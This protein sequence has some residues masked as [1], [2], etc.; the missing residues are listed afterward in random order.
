MMLAFLSL[1]L[2]PEVV[3]Y[4]PR[5]GMSVQAPAGW[6]L[7]ELNGSSLRLDAPDHKVWL[8][9]SAF[10]VTG[11]DARG[12]DWSC[13][14]APGARAVRCDSVRA[15]GDHATKL[16][17]AL[18]GEPA[19]I[20]AL[21]GLDLVRQIAP[22][23]TGFALQPRD[24]GGAGARAISAEEAKLIR[25]TME[26]HAS[27]VAIR[28]LVGARVKEALVFVKLCVDR[29]GVPTEVD[30]VKRCPS[31]SYNAEVAASVWSWRFSPY[32]VEGQ[33]IPFCTA[34]LF[35]LVID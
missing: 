28:E 11:E 30:L 20:A 32:L 33:P 27:P 5:D 22:T 29:N 2:V 25:G 24:P 15:E 18:A 3:A 34:K 16:S 1:A 12:G 26:L 13:T 21:G 35:H 7:Q 23:A 4:T 6:K 9:V 31:S 10:R 17:V 8:T 14:E 19:R